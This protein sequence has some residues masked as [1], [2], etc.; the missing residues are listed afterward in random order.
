M[1]A[2]GFVYRR[3]SGTDMFL[4][5]QEGKTRDAVKIHFAKTNEGP[6]SLVLNPSVTDS[7]ASDDDRYILLRLDPLLEMLLSVFRTEDKMLTRDL[8]DVGLV[9][10]SW[11]TRV[12]PVL[13]PRLKQILDDP[14]G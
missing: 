7:D 9:D 5:G 11:L 6:Y 8:I 2:A 3:S 14:D 10:E 12:H 4:D 1:E 13:A